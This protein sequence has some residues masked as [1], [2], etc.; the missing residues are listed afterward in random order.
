MGLYGGAGLLFYCTSTLPKD[1]IRL[2]E[3]DLDPAEGK[4][5]L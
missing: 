2:R 1:K 4:W 5:P 3:G